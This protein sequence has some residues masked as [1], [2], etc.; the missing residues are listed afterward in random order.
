MSHKWQ[1][2]VALGDSFTVGTGDA[3]N[4]IAPLSATDQLAVILQRTRTDFRYSNLARP[5]LTSTEIRTEQLEFAL[6]LQPDL[7]SIVGG[8]NDILSRAWNPERFEKE[9][10]SMFEPFVRKGATLITAT[11]PH[12]PMITSLP[13]PIGQ[14]LKRN[15]D[16]ANIIIQRLAKELGG[17]CLN[18]GPTYIPYNPAH[19]STDGIHPNTLGYCEISRRLISCIEQHADV[20]IRLDPV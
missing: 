5:S 4:G 8:G 16:N 9:M 6:E 18:M 11:L 13:I 7:V 17:A 14:R 20:K 15:I 12:F 19:W 1:Q 10:Y 2:Y 3:V